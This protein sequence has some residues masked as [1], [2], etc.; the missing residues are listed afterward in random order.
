MCGRYQL[1]DDWQDFPEFKVPAGFVPNNDVRPTNEV[2]VV[3]L[4]EHGDWLGEMRHWGFMR[5]WPGASGKWVKKQ[6]INAVGE[7]LDTKRSFKDAFQRRHCL[8]P[9]SAWYEWP[10]VA[11]KKTRV[12]IGMKGRH[13]FG[14]AGLYE[15]SRHSDTGAAVATFTI[16]T[17]PP[18]EILGSAH[19]RAPLVLQ[20][21]DYQTWLEGGPLAKALIGAHPDNDAFFVEPVGPN[22]P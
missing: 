13:M 6:L 12:R 4:D 22:G 20:D 5:T 15:T 2:P 1:E 11:G 18:N 17:V 3:R 9:M 14:V 10:I 8:V 19:D 7:E 21:D 16:V